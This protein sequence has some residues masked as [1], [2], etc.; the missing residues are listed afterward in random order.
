M[1]SSAPFLDMLVSSDQDYLVSPFPIQRPKTQV[2]CEE[3]LRLSAPRRPEMAS[4]MALAFVVFRLPESLFNPETN[5][6]GGMRGQ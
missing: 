2:A 5:E 1:W 3:T 6:S 4:P